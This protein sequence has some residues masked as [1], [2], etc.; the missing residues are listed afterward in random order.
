MGLG[1]VKF[2]ARKA[3]TRSTKESQLLSYICLGNLFVSTYV[4]PFGSREFALRARM[5]PTPLGGYR[6][7][8]P[9]VRYHGLH[10]TLESSRGVIFRE[11]MPS[12]SAVPLL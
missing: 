11:P 8:L 10:V 1:K 9:F 4:H 12:S 2:G 5:E 6:A 7:V 3:F